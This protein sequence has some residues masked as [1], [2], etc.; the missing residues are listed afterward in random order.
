MGD[1]PAYTVQ[2]FSDGDALPA[3]AEE[4]FR[5]ELAYSRKALPEDRADRGQWRFACICAVTGSGGV[6]GGVHL[7]IGPIN[8]G[9]LAAEKLAFLEQVFVRPEYR[10]HG[11]AAALMQEAFAIARGAGCLHILGHVS[12]DNPAAIALYRT[13]GF[14]LADISDADDGGGYFILKPL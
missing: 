13:C 7:D 1:V 10:R 8:F 4:L 11:I 6:L 3:E 2:S 9:P 12:W 5:E 14:A